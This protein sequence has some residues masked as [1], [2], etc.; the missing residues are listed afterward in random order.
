MSD[1]T[2]GAGSTIVGAQAPKKYVC[3]VRYK[4]RN[5]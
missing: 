3:P 4:C 2:K 1:S 5:Q